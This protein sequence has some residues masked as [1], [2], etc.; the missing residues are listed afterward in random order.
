MWDVGVAGKDA[1]KGLGELPLARVIAAPLLD[2][3]GSR[4]EAMVRVQLGLSRPLHSGWGSR[5]SQTD[6]LVLS[7]QK[8]E[9]NHY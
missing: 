6:M 8:M 2:L 4:G 3:F 1:D 5:S 7:L 9:T